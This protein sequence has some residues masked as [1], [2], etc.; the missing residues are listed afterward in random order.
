M[1]ERRAGI[2]PPEIMKGSSRG[3]VSSRS[4]ALTMRTGHQ[5]EKVQLAVAALER[6]GGFEVEQGGDQP[7]GGIEHHLV[8]RALGTGAGA[9]RILAERKLKKGVQLR[10]RAPSAGVVDNELAGMDVAGAR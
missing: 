10:G 9:G 4:S 3:R 8:Q 6:A 1:R 5:V 7:V 2:A